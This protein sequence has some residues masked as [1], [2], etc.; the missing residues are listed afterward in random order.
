MRSQDSD[1]SLQRWMERWKNEGERR[2]KLLFMTTFIDYHSLSNWNTLK[3]EVCL[4]TCL[5]AR[6]DVNKAFNT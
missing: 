6:Y 1:A 5:N 3:I 2:E 4:F